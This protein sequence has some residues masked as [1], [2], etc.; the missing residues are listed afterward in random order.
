MHWCISCILTSQAA[1]VSKSDRV[2]DNLLTYHQQLLY[3]SSFV[4]L[5]QVCSSLK[6]GL[7]AV[8]EKCGDVRKI[9]EGS[10]YRLDKLQIA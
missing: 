8:I 7:S 6:D 9:Q 4:I 2:S 3:L 10:S 5:I 1:H